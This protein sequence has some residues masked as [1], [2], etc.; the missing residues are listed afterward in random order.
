[1]PSDDPT[2]GE[3]S[4]LL[5]SM[6]D[7]M[8]NGF[9][10]INQRLDR[11]VSMDLFSADQR[12]IDERLNNLADALASEQRARIAAF[13]DEQ[14]ARERQEANVDRDMQRF[15]TFLGAVATSM[16]IP[17]GLF[18]ANLLIGR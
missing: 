2:P 15:K 1:M 12:R 3:L 10:A 18:I 5:Q 4:R 8:R 9:A 13:K 11:Y 16:L 6:R 14:T 7:D 17:I